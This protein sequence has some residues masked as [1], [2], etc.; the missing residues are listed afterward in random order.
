MNTISL[1]WRASYVKLAKSGKLDERV[2][3]LDAMLS[4][5]AVCP[6]ECRVDRRSELGE[7]A[8]GAEPVTS[9]A[10]DQRQPPGVGHRL[11]RQLQPALRV[12]PES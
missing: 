6:R 3:Q 5:C 2:S 9:I 8:T 12:L 7:C 10:Y 1:T 4:D 11:P